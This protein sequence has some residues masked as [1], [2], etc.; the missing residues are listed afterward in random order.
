MLQ[1]RDLHFFGER[2]QSEKTTHCVISTVISFWE[3]EN[4]GGSGEDEESPEVGGRE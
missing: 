3:R 4:C 2:S 1:L